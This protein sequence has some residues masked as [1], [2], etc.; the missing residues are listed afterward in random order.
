MEQE[1]KIKRVLFNEVS[2]AIAAVGMISSLIFWVTNP[3][4]ALEKQVIRLEA[5]VES[6]ETVTKA[7]EKIKNN[8]LH[9]IQLRLDKSDTRQVEILQQIAGL[10]AT[11]EAGLRK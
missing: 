2:F 7:L 6:S 4:N 10:K 5:Q 11:I 8:D 9:E 1:N 3:Q